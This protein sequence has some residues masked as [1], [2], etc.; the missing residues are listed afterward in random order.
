MKNDIENIS[1]ICFHIFKN[2]QNHDWKHLD[3]CSGKRHK[4]LKKINK[5]NED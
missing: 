3:Y 4:K 2:F 5:I 1:N